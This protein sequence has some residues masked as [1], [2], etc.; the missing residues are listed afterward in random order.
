MK[1][2]KLNPASRLRRLTV[3]GRLVLADQVIRMSDKDAKKYLE[4]T[5]NGTKSFVEC[6]EVEGS[7]A[8]VTTVQQTGIQKE[9]QPE[10]AED[11]KDD[12]ETI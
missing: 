1:A 7:D 2:F 10:K 5:I 3:Y 12:V 9:E 4:H 6:D 8:V 11:S